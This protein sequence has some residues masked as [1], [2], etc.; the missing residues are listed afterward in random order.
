[1]DVVLGSSVSQPVINYSAA[2]FAP[3]YFD[4]NIQAA[5]TVSVT[6]AGVPGVVD[7]AAGLTTIAPGS[8]VEIFGG[9]FTSD[10]SGSSDEFGLFCNGVYC[11]YPINFD[12]VSVSFDVPGA[13]YPGFP[14][15]IATGQYPQINLLVPWE[16]E[17][18]SSAQ[19]KV[20][21]DALYGSELFSNVVTVPIA[22][23]VP[24]FFLCSGAVCARDNTTGSV[25]TASNPAKRGQYIQL[26]ANG[27]GPVTNQPPD[28][29]AA[30]ASPL[31]QTP[32]T[33][34]VTIGGATVPASDVAFGGLAPGFPALYQINVKVPATAQT[35][36][37]VPITL[38]IGGTTSPTST[39]IGPV[40]IAVQ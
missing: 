10:L 11:P 32:T 6:S 17:G 19:V 7:A 37:A 21:F 31:S 8:Y 23:Y 30:T 3:D 26:Y 20:S 36:N 12:N 2:G 4:V 33:P 14:Y 15:F 5:P 39:V 13:T 22:N 16:L 1:L 28:G 9:G 29:V 25:I 27:L 35:G 40:T 24:A 38:Q 18:Q 34:V